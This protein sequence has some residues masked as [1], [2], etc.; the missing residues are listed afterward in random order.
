M[1]D[2]TYTFDLERI[3]IGN[4]PLLF[5]VEVVMRTTILYVWTLFM[6]RVTGKR[7][8]GELTA[9]ELLIVIGLGSVVGD[10]MFYPDVPILHG[11]AA[12]ALVVL[13]HHATVMFTNRWPRAHDFVIGRPRQLVADGRLDLKGMGESQISR[14][15]IF[16]GL[17]QE[18]FRHLGQIR[19]LWAEPDGKFSIVPYGVDDVRPGLPFIP[20]DDVEAPV[21]HPAGEPA[22]ESHVFACDYCGFTEAFAAG[23]VLPVCPRCEHDCWQYASDEGVRSGPAPAAA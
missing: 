13:L 5:F 8:M 20:P 23:E 4:L 15:E 10:P 7:G 22:P 14:E 6:L 9:L 16:T 2:G 19:R 3:F 18:R 21:K 17:R 11:M 1:M 12:I